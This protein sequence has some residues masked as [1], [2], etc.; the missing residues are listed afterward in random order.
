MSKNSKH[1]SKMNKRFEMEEKKRRERKG[2]PTADPRI[3]EPQ[4]EAIS[5]VLD[6]SDPRVNE[7]P[8]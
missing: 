7:L 2:L 5:E 8:H 6:A 1:G 4:P 3:P